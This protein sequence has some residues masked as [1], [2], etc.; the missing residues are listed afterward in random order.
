M[1]EPLTRRADQRGQALLLA[2]GGVFV[3]LAGALALVA[4][5][6]AVTGK[7]RVQRAADL[8]AISAVRSMRDDLPRLLAPPALPDG[9]PN[10]RHIEKAAYLA[11][12]RAAALEAAGENGVSPRRLRLS[13]PDGS[14]FAPVRAKAVVIARLE[15]GAGRT[16]VEASAVAEAAA[17]ATATGSM[18]AVASG[19]GYSGPLVYRDGEGMRPDVGAAF[20]R[21][22]AAAARAGVVLIVNSGF[23]SD[24]EQA[25]LFAAHPDP[26]WVAPPGQS[27]H[28]CA[29]ELDLGPET[30][31][32]WL[33]A[34]ARGFGFL[35]RYSYE[36]WHFGFTAGPPPCSAAG[37]QGGGGGDGAF[38]QAGALPS[39]VPPRLKTPLL[40]AAARWNV[41]A[42]LLAAQLMA[43]SN[44]D[45]AAISPA[46]AQGI[47]QFIPST[48]AAYGLRDPFEPTE[49]IDAQAH[50]MS[51]LIRQ[52][53]SPELALAA[54]N[55]GPAPV[56]ACH[57]VP[58]YP[59]TRA[60]VTRILALLGGAGALAVPSFE[61]RLVA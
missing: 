29:T 25:A 14:S 19:G 55:A 42:A 18:P 36:P 30:A 26:K 8:V 45:P 48:A 23:R 10:P 57:C 15:I 27:L 5:A 7:G 58:D 38:A 44:F 11:R 16:R 33:A 53:G 24:A 34:N 3:L 22:A 31:Y 40:G 56:E 59:E 52:F 12:A 61:V 41:S 43:E 49:A 9:S 35:K 1:S 6:G 2:L 13:F 50:L 37:N 60:Y 28:R 20:D 51:D 4:I 54:Y 39:F 46:G 17:P 47:A 21:M 32:G